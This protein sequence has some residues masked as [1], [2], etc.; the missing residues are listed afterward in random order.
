MSMMVF[1][2]AGVVVFKGL[3]ERCGVSD[4]LFEEVDA[5]R[6]IWRKEATH[7]RALFKHCF[8]GGELF[9][10]ACGANDEWFIEADTGFKVC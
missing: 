6:E 8:S 10:P 4:D 2:A 7:V 3:H 9:F 1:D 5:D